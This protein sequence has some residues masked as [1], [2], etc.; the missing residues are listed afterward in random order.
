[1]LI[2]VKLARRLSPTQIVYKTQW[3]NSAHV[4]SVV[5]PSEG[6][7]GGLMIIMEGP[8][9]F[10][11]PSEGWEFLKAMGVAESELVRVQIEEGGKRVQ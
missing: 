2:R 9:D 5:E 8:A 4:V 6:E 11:S 7:C 1:M 3:V 10:A